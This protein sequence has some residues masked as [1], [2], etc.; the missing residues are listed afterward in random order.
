MLL[1][2]FFIIL[3]QS[4]TYAWGQS[5]LQEDYFFVQKIFTPQEKYL[6]PIPPIRLF[7]LLLWYI[8]SEYR[9]LSSGSDS[10]L[11]I[12]DDDKAFQTISSKYKQQTNYNH[13]YFVHIDSNIIFATRF[14]TIIRFVC[15]GEWMLDQTVLT[16]TLIF[17]AY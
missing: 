4:S 2:L 14:T 15:W 11:A 17:E 12:F 1:S 10:E 16:L 5:N 9:L 8:L 7:K 13:S 3:L 6:S